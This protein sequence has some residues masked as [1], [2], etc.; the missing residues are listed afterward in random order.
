MPSPKSG[1]KRKKGVLSVTLAEIAEEYGIPPFILRAM[2]NCG[3]LWPVERD[4]RTRIALCPGRE[5]SRARF[6]DLG[7]RV[8]LADAEM[9]PAPGGNPE[10]VE[11]RDGVPLAQA[12]RDDVD[13]GGSSSPVEVYHPTRP[14]ATPVAASVR[15][16]PA[17]G[18]PA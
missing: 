18:G 11:F 15:T 17:E 13:L 3:L 6:Q 5:W 10:P 4:G 2:L 16:G 9:E 14:A 8:R 12:G 1:H 7:E